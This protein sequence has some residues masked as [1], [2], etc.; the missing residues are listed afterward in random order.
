MNATDL[1]Q[2]AGIEHVLRGSTQPRRAVPTPKRICRS[3]AVARWQSLSIDTRDAG[4]DG[5]PRELAVEVEVAGR[6]VDFERRA[7]RRRPPR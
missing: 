2:R 1:V 7:G 3:S 6:A 4:R 5:R